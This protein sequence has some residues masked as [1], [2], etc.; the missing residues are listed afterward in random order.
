MSS[1]IDDQNLQRDYLSLLQQ[2]TALA[3]SGLYYSKDFFDQERYQNMIKCIEKLLKLSNVIT[4]Q[5]EK[6][7]L[8]DVGYA[9]PKVD[10]RAVIFHEQKILLVKESS[11][12]LWSLPGGWADSGLSA[13]ENVI[14]EVFEETG[15]VVKCKQL[16]AL[17]DMRKHAHPPMFLHVYK[18]FF[19]CEILAGEIKASFET[20]EVDFFDEA[21]LPD[22]ST[23]RVTL[24]QIHSFFTELSNQKNSTEFD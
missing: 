17:T 19:L 16:L 4:T 3:Q 24:E 2:M 5:F 21:S 10:V 15:L 8:N 22:I 7:I 13:S 18:A 11:D 20:P 9:T 6:N 1:S 12:G 14:K 23:P